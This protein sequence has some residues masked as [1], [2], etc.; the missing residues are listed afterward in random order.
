MVLPTVLKNLFPLQRI[1]NEIEAAARARRQAF[2]QLD[3]DRNGRPGGSLPASA[4]ALDDLRAAYELLAG[5]AADKRWG[6]KRLEAK[7]E[8]L[9]K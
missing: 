5:Q 1:R 3:H 7:I 2:H 6:R 4:R 8:A 9:R